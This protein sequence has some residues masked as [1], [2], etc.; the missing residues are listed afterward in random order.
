MSI[1]RLTKKE[2]AKLVRESNKELIEDR[3]SVMSDPEAFTQ[4][5]PAMSGE[6]VA[7]R[8]MKLLTYEKYVNTCLKSLE[9]MVDQVNMDYTNSNMAA[10]DV[11]F[12]INDQLERLRASVGYTVSSLQAIVNNDGLELQPAGAQFPQMMEEEENK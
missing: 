9:G 7:N 6:I 11:E 8:K 5:Y 1:G 4:S 2:L 3:V 12:L 10:A